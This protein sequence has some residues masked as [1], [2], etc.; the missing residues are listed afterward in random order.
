MNK[1]FVK[2]PEDHGDR[3]P[4][5]GSP[6]QVVFQKTLQHHL[7]P[8]QV[9]QLSDTAFFCSQSTCEVV[10]FDR[11]ERA[12][13]ASE[14]QQAVYPKD[15][16]APICPCFG[17][18]EEDIDEDVREGVVTRVKAHRRQAESCDVKCGTLSPNGQSCVPQV[19]RYYM[20]RRIQ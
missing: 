4:C 19:Q 2:E 11:F 18:T 10:Y 15:P 16:S 8:E 14:L 13:S 1:A 9:S 12:V 7:T 20:K 17:L 3:C 5:C 6:G